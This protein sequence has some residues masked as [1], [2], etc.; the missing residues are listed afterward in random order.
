MQQDSP[1]EKLRGA[2]V[3]APQ[4][5]KELLP[6]ID[7]LEAFPEQG[8]EEGLVHLVGV[9]ALGMA[10]SSQGGLWDG[11]KWLFLRG[12]PPDDPENPGSGWLRLP[13]GY[14]DGVFGH[15]VIKVLDQT[16]ALDM[17]LCVS[18]PLLAW[19]RLELLQFDQNRVLALQLSRMNTLFDLTRYLGMGELE[20]K[21]DVAHHFANTL[22]GEFMIQKILVL[23]TQGVVLVSKGLGIIPDSLGAEGLRDLI[24]ARGLTSSA[25]LKDQDRV[26]GFVHFAASMKGEMSGDDH[27][28]LQ[29][30]LNI[31][32]GHLSAID[33]RESRIQ[34]I[35]LEKDM[36]LARNIQRRILPQRLPEP[37]GW[38][39]A[40]AS[41]PYEA[42]GGDL[43]DLW[44]AN[45]AEQGD[46]L[47][48]LI[49]DISGKG[50]PASLMMTQ[51]SAFLRVLADRRVG[52]WGRLARRLN[53][54]MNEVRDR[55]RYSTLFAASLN[56]RNG[57]LRYLN[58]GHNP[59]ILVPGDGGPARR[60]CA[61]G[62]VVGLLP[63]AEFHEGHEAM[64]P[65]DVL[66]AFT[67][68]IVEAEDQ[69]GMEFGDERV[70]AV[71][72][73]SLGAPALEIFEKILVGAFSHIAGNGFRDDATLVV[74]KRS[75]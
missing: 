3:A 9:T 19:R 17:L 47:H 54:L 52:D 37:N 69:H 42:V 14:L 15:L 56:P 23:D 39:C 50:L 44:V 51:I 67:D 21:R 41:L 16:P 34:S 38:Q 11:G 43:Y 58:G 64:A 72:Q 66:V 53:A 27:L 73:H 31:T 59:P 35:K 2:C 28:F 40:A 5:A 61:T 30:L 13:W 70:I 32:S 71:A 10:K 65:G 24:G 25:E 57:D 45:D 22:A 60:L 75:L 6:L 36:E 74:I 46:R 26:H 7:F 49:G 62:P 1:F 55:N 33:M 29:T 8:T 68:G 12:T 18:A 48:M 63:D 4:A 20:G